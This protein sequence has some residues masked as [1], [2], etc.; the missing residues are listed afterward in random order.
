MPKYHNT[1]L[2]KKHLPI[3]GVGPI[4]GVTITVHFIPKIQVIQKQ[5]P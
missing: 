4:Y 1:V 3:Y 2:E 5:T